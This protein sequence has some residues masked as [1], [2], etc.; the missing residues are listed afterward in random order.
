MSSNM[1][2]AILQ[3]RYFFCIIP[4]DLTRINDEKLRR[5]EI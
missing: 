4:E 3:K 2:G 5:K 1:Q